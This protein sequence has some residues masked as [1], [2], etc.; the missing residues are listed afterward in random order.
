M[1]HHDIIS[2]AGA[3]EQERRHL[4]AGL[5]QHAR[6]LEKPG[7]KLKTRFPDQHV[8]LAIPAE[9]FDPDQARKAAAYA[10]EILGMMRQVAEES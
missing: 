3:L 7:Y 2:H 4:T 1:Q 9:Q 8:P 6:A 5:Q 10:D